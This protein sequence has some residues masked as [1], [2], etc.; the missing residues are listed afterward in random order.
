M[1]PEGAALK[2]RARKPAVRKSKSAAAVIEGAGRSRESPGPETGELGGGIQLPSGSAASSQLVAPAS[3][4]KQDGTAE[5]G[6]NQEGDEE[7]DQEE[8]ADY[9]PEYEKYMR[10]KQEQSISN[11][12]YAATF[13]DSKSVKSLVLI[14]LA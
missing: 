11:M 4:S 2:K 10:D 9:D 13:T 5:P 1:D 6:E 14:A 8:L 7:E 12:K 3:Q